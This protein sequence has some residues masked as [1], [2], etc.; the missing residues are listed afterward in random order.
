[1]KRVEAAY[2]LVLTHDIDALTLVELPAG[3]TLTG[4]FFRCLADNLVRFLRGHVSSEQYVKSIVAVMEY[5]K[6]K[7]GHGIDPW[8]KSLDIM[9]D[10]ERLHDVRSTL[11]FIPICGEP[12]VAPSN[13]R[14]AP[15][16]RAAYYHVG[17]CK[18]I[19]RKL[20]ANGWEVGVHGINAWRSAE[21]ARL[22]LQAL[23]E[24]CPS[25]Q[26]IGIRMHWLYAREGM[27]KCLDE[28]GYAYD[29]SYGWNDKI[30]FPGK[31]Y[32]PFWADRS[33]GLIVLPLNI[34]DGALL[35]AE[36]AN[37]SPADA[38]RQVRALLAEAR[39]YQ[40]VVTVLWHN[41]S[42]TAPRFW[43]AVYEQV[44]R[45]A[46]SDGAEI[47]TAGQAVERFREASVL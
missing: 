45:Q 24:A 4:F 13:G 21:D 26:R 31:R 33:G 10:M 42:F 5:L 14:P 8:A 18:E 43:G 29:A 39:R 32:T 34:Q 9:L 38:L 40:A 15:R 11:F 41:T 44:L 36:Y 1:M 6:A 46:K 7:R 28:A 27:W 17:S 30:G 19:L 47:L 35:G 3:R 25:Q 2:I 16:N 12:G 37:L 22:E 23:R 20:V